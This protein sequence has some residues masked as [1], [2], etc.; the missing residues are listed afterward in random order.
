M[1][2]I[3]K[4]EWRYAT[5][6]F[7]TTRKIPREDLE[8]IK[9]SIQLAPSSYGLQLY[10][11]III[12]NQKL[13]EALKP[14]SD[15]QNQITDCSH[16]FV[17]CNYTSVNDEYI[18]EYVLLKSKTQQIDIKQLETYGTYLKTKL[19]KKTQEQRTNWLKN[20]SYLALG[21]LLAACADLKIDACPM[22]G[23]DSEQYNRVLEL[24][25]G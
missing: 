25:K 3:N 2:F 14:I 15:N 18:D 1:E 19:S 8:L 9:R 23:F 4:M 22:E 24:E 10:K 11:V 13:K 6:L 7:D 5:K 20:Q 21:N 17:F 12:E 16:L